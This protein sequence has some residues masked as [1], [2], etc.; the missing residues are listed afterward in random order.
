MNHQYP[1]ELVSATVAPPEQDFFSRSGPAPAS[2]DDM[3]RFPRFYYRT[4]VAATIYPL[5]GTHGASP[6]PCTLLTRDLSRG[7]MNVLHTEQLFPGQ[8]I[9]LVLPDGVCRSVE[10]VWCRRLA[11]RCW[12]AGCRFIQPDRE[13]SDAG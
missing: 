7:G 12:S 9:D 11:A 5:P 6:T 10:V 3:R 1:P 2:F 4:Q 8:R 13:N